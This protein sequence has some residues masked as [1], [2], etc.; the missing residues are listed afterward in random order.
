MSSTTGGSSFVLGTSTSGTATRNLVHSSSK[1]PS[2]LQG[3]PRSLFTVSAA[4]FW[5]SGSLLKVLAFTT[6]PSV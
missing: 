3:T 4:A 1:S 2:G 6:V 5:L